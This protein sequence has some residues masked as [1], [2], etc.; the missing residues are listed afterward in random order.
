MVTNIIKRVHLDYIQD[1]IDNEGISNVNDKYYTNAASDI[2]NILGPAFAEALKRHVDSL[3]LRMLDATRELVRYYAASATNT[4]IGVNCYYKQTPKLTN[5]QLIA[6][7]N[8]EEK[9]FDGMQLYLDQSI[10][11]LS[12]EE[13]KSTGKSNFGIKDTMG[14]FRKLSMASET[15]LTD[16]ILDK[17]TQ[18]DNNFNTLNFEE[19]CKEANDQE[20]AIARH[21][22]LDTHF[23]LS[24]QERIIRNYMFCFFK[25][26]LKKSIKLSQVAQKPVQ[27]KEIYMKYFDE[28][29]AEL[30][31]D[32]RELIDGTFANIPLICSRI[33]D[34]F[35]GIFTSKNIIALIK[36]RTDADK[37]DID[38]MVTYC[39]TKFAP[40]KSKPTVPEK[41]EVKSL[42]NTM[43]KIGRAHV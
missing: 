40:T 6:V 24:F 12:S 41:N 22:S 39:E 2:F 28:S 43:E 27:D 34:T 14:S 26:V 38:E 18:F 16:G 21:I 32:L 11:H 42:P 4:L 17:F 33:R 37:K 7:L 3:T 25:S 15:R 20:E 5:E 1:L 13:S 19:I 31:D 8:N 9:F 10:S 23:R 30:F 29:K 36:Q 35:P